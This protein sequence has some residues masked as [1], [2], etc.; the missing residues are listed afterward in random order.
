M[1]S[2]ATTTIAC[3]T[4]VDDERGLC[5]WNITVVSGEDHL[6]NSRLEIESIRD[7]GYISDV[8]FDSPNFGL[9]VRPR[10]IHF[11]TR[12]WINNQT[13]LLY[14]KRAGHSTAPHI[15]KFPQNLANFNKFNKNKLAT[16]LAI[17]KQNI[18]IKIFS[19]LANFW[20]NVG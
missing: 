5:C 10:M 11:H 19:N 15:C 9:A 17:L 1:I 6:L 7:I 13:R 20:A 2:N 16:Y 14:K 18:E 3:V 8:P 12:L 4:S